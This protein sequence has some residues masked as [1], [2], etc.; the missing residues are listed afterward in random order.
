MR[1]D[2]AGV[3]PPHTPD[4]IYRRFRPVTI[5]HDTYAWFADCLLKVSRLQV[6]ACPHCIKQT[7]RP[8]IAVGPLPCFRPLN[9]LHRLNACLTA[10]A[11]FHKGLEH[12]DTMEKASLIFSTSSHDRCFYGCINIQ[13][14]L[15]LP[16]VERYGGT[17]EQGKVQLT[18]LVKHPPGFVPTGGE[19]LVVKDWHRALALLENPDNLLIEPPARIVFLPFEIAVINPVLSDKHDAIHRKLLAPECQGFTYCVKYRNAFRFAHF[20]SQSA[21]LK[22][23][24]VNGH[25]VHPRRSM[26]PLPPITVQ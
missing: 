21:F 22:L 9:A 19:V 5:V 8:G 2:V 10:P 24:D 14:Y 15:G 11:A 1:F 17:A 3:G 23:M 20:L 12:I 18:R 25:N 16:V 7:A 4:R 26:G 13:L 6:K